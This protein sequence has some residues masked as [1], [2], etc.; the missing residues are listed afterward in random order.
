VRALH[1]NPWQAAPGNH[2]LRTA[3]ARS[4]ARHPGGSEAGWREQEYGSQISSLV[5][6][7][8]N[9]M[10]VEEM[11]DQVPPSEQVRDL[12]QEAHAN[13]KWLQLLLKVC[14]LRDR[15]KGWDGSPSKKHA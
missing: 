5:R 12:I 6:S 14:M 2:A 3:A 10:T 13:V 7:R 1:G 11:F 8:N 9:Q 15:L 4:H